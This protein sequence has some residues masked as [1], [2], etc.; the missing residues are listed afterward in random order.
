MTDVQKSPMN[1]LKEALRFGGFREEVFE[2][3]S[4]SGERRMIPPFMTNL[5]AGNLSLTIEF[6]DEIKSKN[7]AKRISYD[8]LLKNMYPE[9]Y[10]L[11]YEDSADY[12]ECAAT[13]ISKV[14]VLKAKRESMVHHE[15]VY[16]RLCR[17]VEKEKNEEKKEKML[18]RKKQV[19]EE[20]TEAVQRNRFPTWDELDTIEDPEK[21]WYNRMMKATRAYDLDIDWDFEFDFEDKENKKVTCTVQV[22]QRKEEGADPTFMFKLDH[23]AELGN[24]ADEEKEGRFRNKGEFVRQIKGQLSEDIVNQLITEGIMEDADSATAIL[25]TK[26]EAAIEARLAETD[27]ER[28]A[29]IEKVKEERKAAK[30]AGT[31]KEGKDGKKKTMRQKLKEKKE[32]KNNKQTE[33][34]KKAAL[35]EKIAA[36]KEK[37]KLKAKAKRDAKKG[38]KEEEEKPAAKGKKAPAKGAKKDQKPAP[39]NKTK[40]ELRKFYLDTIKKV[41]ANEKLDEEKKKK[42]CDK[43][44]K[45]YN[46]KLD[47][48][49]E[50]N[51][52]GRNTQRSDERA[53]RR[54]QGRRDDRDSRAPKRG[55]RDEGRSDRRGPKSAHYAPQ[56]VMYAQPVMMPQQMYAPPPSQAA[57]PQ[58]VYSNQSYGYQ[59]KKDNNF[60]GAQNQIQQLQAQQQ[61]Q[62]AQLQQQLTSQMNQYSRPAPQQ[63]SGARSGGRRW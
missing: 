1:L 41:S 49:K 53:P 7:S 17:D 25:K 16:K 14:A 54:E 29:R 31:L 48:L 44:K 6:G 46:E 4:T 51:K 5:T 42:L 62:M 47:A 9:E 36:K 12:A 2:C 52:S 39:G 55:G 50:A 34:A 22:H 11:A 26:S 13:E 28:A 38:K 30:K 24:G 60:S 20:R 27:E 3:E 21:V 37:L 18:A 10:E 59:G 19:F 33:K 61:A 45:I 23:S 15:R 56:P 57:Y 8:V 35:E 43:Y 63:S 40:A 32:A 58:Q